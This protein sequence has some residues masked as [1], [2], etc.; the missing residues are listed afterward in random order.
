MKIQKRREPS[1]TDNTKTAEDKLNIPKL[2]AKI[3]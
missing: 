1:K 2:L 3:S